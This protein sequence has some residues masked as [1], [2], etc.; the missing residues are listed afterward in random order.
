MN[1]TK[2]IFF[3]VH[4][5]NTSHHILITPPTLRPK[6]SQYIVSGCRS[7]SMTLCIH[8]FLCSLPPSVN[9]VLLPV[10]VSVSPAFPNSTTLEGVSVKVVQVIT[11]SLEVSMS[12]RGRVSG[13]LDQEG[14]FLYTTYNLLS[15]MMVVNS[16]KLYNCNVPD[17]EPKNLDCSKNGTF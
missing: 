17:T 1:D 7:F 13:I 6:D 8:K 2:V 4:T 12:N 15:F 11:M 9:C 5:K 10:A 14:F 16:G 3:L